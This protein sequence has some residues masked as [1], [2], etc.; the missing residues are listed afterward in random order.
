MRALFALGVSSVCLLVVGAAA[1][2]GEDPSPVQ[3]GGNADAA[4][5]DG[6]QSSSTD[7]GG[8]P[9]QDSGTTC[10]APLAD[11]DG[12]GSCET[13]TATEPKHCGACGH[14]CGG[15]TCQNGRCQPQTIA[16][17]VNAPLSL[18]VNSSGVFWIRAEAAEK[19][20]KSGCVGTPTLLANSSTQKDALGRRQIFVDETKAYWLGD[21]SSPGTD[22]Y[23]YVCDV[24]GCGRQPTTIGDYTGVGQLVGNKTSLF[25][26]DST[27]QLKRVPLA[28]GA[29]E[30]LS[31]V[32]KSDSFGFAVDD[33]SIVFSNTD[34]SA[35]GAGGVWIGKIENKNPTKLMDKGLHVAIAGGTT[36]LASVDINVTQST[37]VS[38]PVTGCGGTGTPLFSAPEGSIN[39]IV[40]DGTA[41]YWAVK[42]TAGVADGKIRAC[43][44]PGCPGGPE[45]IA[46]GQA[47]PYA[48]ALDGEFVYWANKGTGGANTGSIARVRR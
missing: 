23:I 22:V 11:C 45:T 37:V 29:Q 14:D 28:A 6:A 47:N 46:E 41:V 35:T 8:D 15:G 42:A 12:N 33:S 48:L 19:C 43:K 1:C 36:V 20:A 44:L 31:A 17:N 16:P 40:A 24:G 27:G 34:F 13:S 32:Y 39:D 2:V 9:G 7:A 18:A 4:P 21:S 26:Y 38:C 10:S 25:W 5:Q 3:P 30:Y